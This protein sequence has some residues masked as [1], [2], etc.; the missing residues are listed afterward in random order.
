MT[1]YREA[2]VDIQ[3]GD[4]FVKRIGPFVRSTFRPE[5][6]GDLGGFGGLFRFPSEKYREPILVSG[7]DGVGTKVKLARMMN[8]HDTIGIDLV[9]MCVNDILVSGAEPL[10]FLDY[11]ATGHL[12][13]DVAEAIV[14]GI[15]EGCRQA[16]CASLVAKPLRCRLVTLGRNMIWLALP[17]V[18]SNDQKCWEKKKFSKE[19]S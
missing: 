8:R 12:E 13:I 4:E 6:M 3:R 10:F 18:W 9:A 2:G 5:V 1:T 19:M 15:A 11:L 14:Q 17:S 7:T 16:G